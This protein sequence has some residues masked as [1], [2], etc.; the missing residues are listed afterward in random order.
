MI[1]FLIHTA[2]NLISIVILIWHCLVHPIF[3]SFGFWYFGHISC[4]IFFPFFFRLAHLALQNVNKDYA[5]F[6]YFRNM[7]ANRFWTK[8]PQAGHSE[9]WAEWSNSSRFNMIFRQQMLWSKLIFVPV[10]CGS[11]GIEANSYLLPL[12]YMHTTYISTV[13]C[14]YIQGNFYIV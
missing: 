3:L 9:H 5:I 8:N 6:L 12:Y 1:H 2:N 11:L 4:V 7:N 13:H 14:K 10:P